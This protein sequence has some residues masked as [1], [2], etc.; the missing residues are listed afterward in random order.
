MISCSY[1]QICMEICIILH[2]QIKSGIDTDSISNRVEPRS[3]NPKI[4]ERLRL[5]ILG[6]C[7]SEKTFFKKKTESL[8]FGA[9]TRS[10]FDKIDSNSAAKKNSGSAALL[11]IP[12][13]IVFCFL[14]VMGKNRSFRI[15][16]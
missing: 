2:V 7:L 12:N 15:T 14:V 9:G 4:W 1:R 11:L 8:Y 3:K 5:P 13:L 16:G 6:F 10:M